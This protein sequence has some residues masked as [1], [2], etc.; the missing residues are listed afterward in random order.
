MKSN[1]WWDNGLPIFFQT[2][3]NGRNISEFKNLNLSF[4]HENMSYQQTSLKQLKIILFIKKIGKD[5]T[6][7]ETQQNFKSGQI[8][9]LSCKLS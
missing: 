5:Y 9:S 3:S 6:G 7:I 1:E 2:G 8:F 4:F